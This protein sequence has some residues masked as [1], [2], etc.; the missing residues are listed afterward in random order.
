MSGSKKPQILGYPRHLLNSRCLF[1]S[2]FCFPMGV[3]SP[4]GCTIRAV[5]VIV[6]FVSFGSIPPACPPRWQL[7][8]K[9]APHAMRPGGPSALRRR[10]LPTTY[11]SSCIDILLV[12]KIKLQNGSGTTS[13]RIA[14]LPPLKLRQDCPS[15]TAKAALLHL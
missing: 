6:H 3:S 1:D 9:H 4:A 10:G 7:L 12:L 2:A 15:L 14:A 5:A 13:G 8:A 11:S